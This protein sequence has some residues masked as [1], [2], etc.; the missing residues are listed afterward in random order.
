MFSRFQ[1]A[2]VAPFFF[3]A[4]TGCAHLNAEPNRLNS[5]ALHQRLLVLD[6]HLDT[7]ARMEYADFNILERH[8]PD[9]DFSQVDLPRMIEGGLDGG[10]W[11]I[12]TDQ[13]PLT[14]EG[15]AA[16]LETAMRR[17]DII[18]DMTAN[19][20][21]EFTLATRT[22]DAKNISETGRRVVYQSIENAYPLGRDLS[23]VSTFYD[24]GVRMIG[25]VHTSNN[26]FSDSSTDEAGPR[27]N[28]LSPLGRQLIAEA[29]RLGMI[30]D[31]SHASDTALSQ[32]IDLSKTPVILSHSGAKDVYDHP[33]NV[34]DDLLVKLAAS[35]GVIQMN[36]LGW[37]LTDLKDP[38]GH[39]EAIAAVF[40]AHA[41]SPH[42][43]TE[44]EAA[45]FTSDLRAAFAQYPEAKASFE[46]FIDQFLHV[47]ELIGPEHVGVGA[48]WDGGGGTIDFN[49]VSVLQHL[50]S[51]LLAEG[52]T[53]DDLTLIWGGNVLRLLKQAHVYAAS[54][55]AE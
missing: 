2:L 47:L 20:P 15:Y 5:D 55:D 13:G 35:G 10:F 1:T 42:E 46:D 34:S 4:L 53:E 33:R 28:G 24:L 52:Y 19:Y 39:D 36:N 51:R 6:T 14:E 25:P 50:T 18:R 9:H 16:A 38:D 49:D 40:T 12:F 23:L 48:D 31:A 29:N 17:S 45:A 21:D 37:Y 30:V 8:D 22:E 32:M 27:W 43:M 3:S 7:P 44:R 11:V 54:Q 41:T 26:Q